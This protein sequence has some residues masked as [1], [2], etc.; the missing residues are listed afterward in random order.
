MAARRE[1]LD[2]F[3]PVGRDLNQVVTLEPAIMKQVRGNPE[4]HG[5]SRL[6]LP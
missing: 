1:Q 3:E 5:R 6:P 4:T 2:R